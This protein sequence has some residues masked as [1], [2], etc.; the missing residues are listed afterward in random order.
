[1]DSF[2]RRYLG[3]NRNAVFI[4]VCSGF[5]GKDYLIEMGLLGANVTEN[6]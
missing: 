3:H 1:M 5:S 2:I 6:Q 4:M